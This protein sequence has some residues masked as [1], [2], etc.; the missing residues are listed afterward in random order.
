MVM[1][2]AALSVEAMPL[3]CIRG[4]SWHMRGTPHP[5]VH[6]PSIKSKPAASHRNRYFY[7]T[8]SRVADQEGLSRHEGIRP[9][10]PSLGI[11]ARTVQRGQ[12]MSSPLA[13]NLQTSRH[14]LRGFTGE[15]WSNYP[16]MSFPWAE[17]RLDDL[18]F[19]ALQVLQTVL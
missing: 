6:N 10:P 15:T 11:N 18:G 3:N 1:A 13:T 19:Q 9:R 12:F 8:I 4:S 7:V 2:A 14:R 17:L 5:Q 16:G